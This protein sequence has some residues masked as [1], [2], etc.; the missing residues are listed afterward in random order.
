MSQALHSLA[1]TTHLIRK[2]IRESTL[3][4]AELARRYNVS[5]QTI[6]K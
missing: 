2:E 1:R 3:S 4:Q 6:R 5:R